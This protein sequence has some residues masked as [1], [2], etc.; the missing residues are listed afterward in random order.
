MITAQHE[1]TRFDNYKRK[2]NSS[3]EYE[4]HPCSKIRDR[5]ANDMER[6]KYRIQTG[7]NGNTDSIFIISSNLPANIAIGDKIEGL[8]KVWT[9]M[10]TGYYFNQTRIVNNGIM[11]DEYLI[12]RCPKGLNLQ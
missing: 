11:S 12:K 4:D 7:V 1:N 3:Y 9:V 5:N 10:S 6:Q 8:G 2:E